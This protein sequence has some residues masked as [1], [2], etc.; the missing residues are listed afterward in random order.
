MNGMSTPP[1]MLLRRLLVLPRLPRPLFHATYFTLLI[2][3]L[4]RIDVRR[5]L[6]RSSYRLVCAGTQRYTRY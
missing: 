4:A 6:F 2:R 5:G 1:V 3:H